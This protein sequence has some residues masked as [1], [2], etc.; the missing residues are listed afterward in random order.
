MLVRKFGVLINQEGDH[1]QVAGN[2]FSILRSKSLK[3]CANTD[4][5]VLFGDFIGNQWCQL[6]LNLNL[7]TRVSPFFVARCVIG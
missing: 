1:S 3:L 2:L 6:A 4:F 7:A 5:D